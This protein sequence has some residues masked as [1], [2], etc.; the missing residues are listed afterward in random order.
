MDLN[1]FV[2]TLG[3]AAEG[4]LSKNKPYNTI[5]EFLDHLAHLHPKKPAVA[6]PSFDPP[7]LAWGHAFLSKEIGLWQR[8]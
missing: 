2:C 8:R 3:Q 6:F 5:N 4:G 1:Y 7:D